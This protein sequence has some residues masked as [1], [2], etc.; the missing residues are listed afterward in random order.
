MSNLFNFYVAS[1]DDGTYSASE[2][3]DFLTDTSPPYA[4]A[5]TNPFVPDRP[6]RFAPST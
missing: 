6:A 1:S 5:S 2:S 3:S 4:P